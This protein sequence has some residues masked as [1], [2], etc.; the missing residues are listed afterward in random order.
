MGDIKWNA[1]GQTDR[2]T[3][4]FSL[5][6]Y[7][8]T[9]L[10]ARKWDVALGWYRTF[11]AHLLFWQVSHACWH[12]FWG[13][14]SYCHW[15]SDTA[16]QSQWYVYLTVTVSKLV[17]PLFWD[18]AHLWLLYILCI[19]NHRIPTWRLVCKNA[20]SYGYCA[21]WCNCIV[22]VQFTWHL[23]LVDLF[24]SNLIQQKLWFVLDIF[25][26]S[27]NEH[28]ECCTKLLVAN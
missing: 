27:S 23:Y 18:C 12:L 19:L 22:F 20:Y 10:L 28:T 6:S 15:L 5:L 2:Q 9:K 25:H 1:D 3:D 7:R 16:W 21:H 4:G 26:A 14:H 8:W 13:V 11:S 24:S 17:K